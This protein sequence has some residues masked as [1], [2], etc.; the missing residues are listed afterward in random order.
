MRFTR[1]FRLQGD[2]D[3]APALH[4]LNLLGY[5]V[6][7][8]APVATARVSATLLSA[9]VRVFNWSSLACGLVEFEEKAASEAAEAKN[10][11]V[12]RRA[13]APPIDENPSSCVSGFAPSW[14]SHRT[15]RAL[16]RAQRTGGILHSH[17]FAVPRDT[18]QERYLMKDD[19]DWLVFNK[20]KVMPSNQA[21]PRS[22]TTPL[23]NPSPPCPVQ[24]QARARAG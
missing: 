13:R 16:S 19:D 23:S 14:H 1:R 11:N 5:T 18:A 4:R 17:A 22:G 2:R 24:V 12:S 10:M 3:F 7:V 15:W 9:A 21:R 20:K 8:A 6:L